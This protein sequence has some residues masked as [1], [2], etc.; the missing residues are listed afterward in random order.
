[1]T[2]LTDIER[3]AKH[4]ANKRQ[5]LRERLD[6]YEDELRKI[7]LRHYKGIR[8]A[9]IAASQA[10]DRLHIAIES[11]PE[12]F[13]KP[14]THNLNGI[15]CGYQ[16]SKGKIETTAKTCDLIRKHLPDQADVLIKSTEAP[17]SK[18]LDQLSAAE[19]KKI[20]A[21]VIPG[22]DRIHIKATDSDLDKLVDAL[23]KEARE[24]GE[25]QETANA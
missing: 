22:K 6:A 2:T 17:I 4:Y 10:E 25:L 1:M 23:M 12:L 18:A 19:L 11:A 3:T 9:Q 5:I 21:K 13:Q 8:A 24:Q 14:K 20:G 15:R 16:R 7:K